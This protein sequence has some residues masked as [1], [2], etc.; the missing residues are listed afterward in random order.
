MSPLHREAHAATRDQQQPRDVRPRRV[1][2]PGLPFAV[3]PLDLLDATLGDR[4]PDRRCR[5]PSPSEECTG[6]VRGVGGE[7]RHLL[8]D[9]DEVLC[10]EA[11]QRTSVAR[12]GGFPQVMRCQ[13]KQRVRFYRLTL[14]AHLHMAKNLPTNTQQ[15]IF[16]RRV[17]AGK[18]FL[19]LIL[20]FLRKQVHKTKN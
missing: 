15:R 6:V 8:P 19:T 14:R 13:V 9:H 20:I 16:L 2:L 5:P 18:E 17:F 4:T 3:G 1:Y 11:G 10:Q 7:E 12:R